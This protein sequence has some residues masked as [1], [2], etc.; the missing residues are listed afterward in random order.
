MSYSHIVTS[1]YVSVMNLDTGVVTKVQSNEPQFSRAVELI[2]AGKLEEVER[3]S[4]KNMVAD[5][6]QSASAK[7]ADFVVRLSGGRVMYSWKGQ[8]EK[9]LHNSMTERVIRMAQEGYDV[10]PLVN[11]MTNLMNNPSKTSIDELYLFLEATGLPITS[12]GHFIAYKIV[13]DDYTSIHDVSFRNDVGTFVEM[14]R[15]EVDD[16]RDR[17]CSQGLHFCSK[18]Y[19]NKYGSGS[20]DS[21]RLVLVKIN[22]ADV[23]SIPSDYNNAKG[24]AS[25]YL[26]WKDITETDWR[27][28]FTQEDYTSKPVEVVENE[29][30][31]VSE[32]MSFTSWNEVNTVSEVVC[33]ECGSGQVHKK[34]TTELADGT[35]KQRYKCQYCGNPFSKVI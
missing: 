20:Y 21:D 29:F 1:N 2:K 12:D 33:P 18:E 11:F 9:E 16:N 10:K 27:N 31:D 6:T 17:T 8:P 4:V 15:H 3:M 23:V 26:I 19:L 22:P 13:R 14:P 25:K 7:S 35:V 24:R 30:V 34:G 32:P 5:F 28:R